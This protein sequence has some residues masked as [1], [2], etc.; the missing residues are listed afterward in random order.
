MATKSSIIIFYLR[1]SRNTHGLLRIASWITFAVVNVA[2]LI[3]T[4]FNIF[5]CIPVSEVFAPAGTCIPLI[6]LYLASVPVNVI[7][8]IAVLV[9]P[10]PVLTGMQL[11]RK[12]K[13]ILIATFGLGVYVIATDIVRIY[14]LQQSSSGYSGASQAD[15]SPLL[16]DEVNFAWYASLSFMWSAVE[17]NVGIICACVPTL[18]PLISRILPNLIYSNHGTLCF[19]SVSKSSN[20]APTAVSSPISGRTNG[21]TS[22]APSPISPLRPVWTTV[23]T[24]DLL[25]SRDESLFASRGRDQIS[26]N[27]TEEI[28]PPPSVAGGS[29]QVTQTGPVR[30][31][32]QIGQVEA[33]DF[34]TSP[35]MDPARIPRASTALTRTEAEVYFGFITIRR[36]TSLVRTSSRDSIKYCVMVTVLFFLCGFSHGLWNNLNDQISRISSNSMSRTLGLY[37]AYYGAYFFG[38][39]TLGQ[40]VLRTGS[41]KAS[42]II[43]LCISGTGIFM[44]WPSAVLLSYTG[45]VISNFVV[46]FGLSIIE[47]ATNP[48][49]ALCGPSYYSEIRLLIAQGFQAIGKLVGMLIAEKGLFQDVRDGP[50]LLDIQWLYMA[51][52][53]SDVV[54]ALIFYYLPLPESTDD[55]LQLQSHPGLPQLNHIVTAEPEQRFKTTNWRVI[56]VTLTLGF[57]SLFL[58]SGVQMANVIWL[59]SSLN[60]QAILK[61]SRL[62]LTAI[63]YGIIANATF[64][65][66]RFIFAGLC[67]LIPPRILLLASFAGSIIFL[68]LIFAINGLNPDTLGAF[69]ILLYFFEGPIWP[70]IYALSLRGMGRKTKI[71]AATLTSAIGGSAVIP[72]IIWAITKDDRRTVQYSYCA[73]IAFLGLAALFPI[74][75]SVLSGARKQVDQGQ[76]KSSGDVF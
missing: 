17:V 75:L 26:P 35:G 53:L 39:P 57:W 40:Y 9:L 16:G 21:Q 37:S 73:L 28:Q 31:V 20:N 50:S 61:A 25:V 41:F 15:T 65:S 14:Y 10:I 44:Y 5:Q 42:F 71:A 12:Q 49:L 22:P 69:L 7:T 70:L 29:T 45:F 54:L 47:T 72:W 60:T 6:T 48:F 43:G 74:Y 3:L 66:G 58:Y 64:A 4:F 2:G 67:F 24:D 30:Q 38:P 52:A 36:P 32:G 27:A 59:T 33:L 8:D 34:V 18:K 19:G 62:S 1:L 68:I 11:P 46:G 13:T 76:K 55:D 56:Y 23:N 51:V 63:S